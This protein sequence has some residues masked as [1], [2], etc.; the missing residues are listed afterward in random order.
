MPFVI[1]WL[2]SFAVHIR[3][4]LRFGVICDRGS[5]AALYTRDHFT[6]R[7]LHFEPKAF[8]LR[9]V[10]VIE[11]FKQRD[12]FDNEAASF[13]Y[14]RC[15]KRRKIILFAVFRWGEIILQSG[16]SILSRKV[17]KVYLCSQCV[18]N[19]RRHIYIFMI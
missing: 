6:E 11:P 5:F 3:D 10:D 13:Y 7:L 1:F 4:H 9:E 19:K 2:G 16:Y 15:F 14:K 17:G 8:C 18:L 12:L